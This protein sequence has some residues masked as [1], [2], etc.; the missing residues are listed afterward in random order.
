MASIITLSLIV[1]VKTARFSDN[2]EQS[3]DTRF[4]KY[5]VWLPPAV[6]ISSSERRTHSVESDDKVS[7]FIVI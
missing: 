3:V 7:V 4:S 5:V 2:Q 6:A 1:I